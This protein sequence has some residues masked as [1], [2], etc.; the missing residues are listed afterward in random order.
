MFAALV[1]TIHVLSVFWLV[2]GILGRDVVYANAR[3]AKSLETLRT[4]VGLGSVF[5]IRFV[6]PA[7]FVVLVT[8]LLAAWLRGSP[9]LGFLRGTGPYWLPLALL[10]YLS[11]IPMIALVFIP[12]GR[13]YRQALDEATAKRGITPALRAALHDRA[14]DAARTYEIVMV[15]TLAWLMIAKPF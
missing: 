10:I 1:V 8:G 15:A 6:R 11:I 2:A 14:V 3:G 5:E 13:V 12:R 4:L 7:T 9:I